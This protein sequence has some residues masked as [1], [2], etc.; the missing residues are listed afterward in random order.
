MI[1]PPPR[2]PPP[3]KKMKIYHDLK[4]CTV[5]STK[6]LPSVH[7]PNSFEAPMERKR[8]LKNKRN[9]GCFFFFIN[10][11][12]RNV[13][14]HVNFCPPKFAFSRLAKI[15]VH[16]KIVSCSLSLSRLFEI[17]LKFSFISFNGGGSSGGSFTF[18]CSFF[19][20][21][22]LFLGLFALFRDWLLP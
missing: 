12:Q 9:Q 10:W 11:I 15:I 7:T 16:V 1:F 18:H 6:P 19:F 8:I 21:F 22:L 4:R 13:V 5:I 14:K 2:P 17:Y 20:R 3:T